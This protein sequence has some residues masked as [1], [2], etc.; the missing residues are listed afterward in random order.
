MRD[1][2]LMEIR[3][4]FEERGFKPGEGLFYPALSAQLGNPRPD[5]LAAAIEE[6]VSTNAFT[7]KDD[8][9]KLS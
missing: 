6:A 1:T 9:L 3:A 4:L 2:N 8:W 7:W 5:S